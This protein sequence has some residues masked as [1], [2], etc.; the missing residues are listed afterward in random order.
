MA[1]TSL[2]LAFLFFLKGE[3]NE[4]SQNVQIWQQAPFHIDCVQDPLQERSGRSY[5]RRNPTVSH[6]LLSP[7]QCVPFPVREQERETTSDVE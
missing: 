1:N 6:G 3:K 7:A 5:A 2:L 4:T